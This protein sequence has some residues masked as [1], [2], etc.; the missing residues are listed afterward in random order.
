MTANPLALS[1][2]V[3]NDRDDIVRVDA[4]AVRVF[5][6]TS[7]DTDLF[8]SWT[9]GKSPRTAGSYANAVGHFARFLDD[10]MRTNVAGVR[11][12][13]SLNVGT[14]DTFEAVAAVLF[15]AGRAAV[16][17]MLRDYMGVQTE[18][19][20]TPATVNGR[21]TAVRSLLAFGAELDL[22]PW[23]LR[24]KAL[25]SVAY[26]DTRGPGVKAVGKMVAA[27]AGRKDTPKRHRDLAIQRMLFDLGLRRAEVCSLDLEHLE[28]DGDEP[29]VWVLG[30]GRKDREALTLPRETVAALRA[31][32]A[33]RGGHP[34]ALFVALDNAH[35]GQRLDGSGLAW[36]VRQ[37]G[38]EA[39]VGHVRPH[40]L[41]HCGATALLDQ[42]TPIRDVQRWARHKSPDILTR[43]YDD[44]RE[45]LAGRAAAKLAASV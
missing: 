26:R 39:G 11:L 33:V 30:K 18:A 2:H 12:R 36:V 24:L 5:E 21:V 3:P 17:R 45:D 14:V 34:G 44:A 42:G 8:T 4:T 32:I 6:E 29:R 37:A 40:G 16:T 1:V 10:W 13:E 35:R 28:L 15:A 20:L 9:A 23:T 19:G 43:F 25:P 41:R 27:I 22:I 38:R 31:W 7:T